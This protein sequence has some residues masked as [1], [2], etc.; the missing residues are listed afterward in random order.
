MTKHS[1]LPC[2]NQAVQ[3][4]PVKIHGE[5][6]G[7]ELESGRVLRCQLNKHNGGSGGVFA[8]E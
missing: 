5:C 6:Y 2:R 7:V 3:L 4:V 8:R 1:V